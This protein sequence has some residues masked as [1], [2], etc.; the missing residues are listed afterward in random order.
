MRRLDID[1]LD[2]LVVDPEAERTGHVAPP[3]QVA[4]S[5]PA[6]EPSAPRPAPPTPA[7]PLAARPWVWL[8]ALTVAAGAAAWLVA[9]APTAVHADAAPAPT[10]LPVAAAPARP[11]SRAEVSAAPPDAAAPAQDP[12]PEAPIQAPAAP[13]AA[14]PPAP[15]SPRQVGSV[16]FGFDSADPDPASLAAARRAAEACASA[17]DLV[18]YACD[19]GDPAYNAGLALR[20]AERVAAVLRG[21]GRSTAVSRDRVPAAPSAPVDRRHQRRV[22]LHCTTQQEN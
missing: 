9:P 11:P 19:V 17:V 3:P 13:P 22:D 10:A 7:R 15:P 18:G 21:D 2:G 16:Y 5:S 1:A 12:T 6:P 14:P 8:A 20:R 4:A